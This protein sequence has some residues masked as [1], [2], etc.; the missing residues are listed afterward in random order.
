MNHT[1]RGIQALA[2]IR[3]A[4]TGKWIVQS[5]F[6]VAILE[7][8]VQGCRLRSL[9]PSCAATATAASAETKSTAATLPQSRRGAERVI[10]ANVE[11]VGSVRHRSHIVKV[12]NVAWEIR[13]RDKRKKTR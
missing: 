9:S 2:G 1:N 4:N 11:V 6:R 13:R 7:T 5:V 12:L 10:Q 3:S 8:K